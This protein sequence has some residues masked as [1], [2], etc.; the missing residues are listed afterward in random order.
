MAGRLPRLTADELIRIL[1]RHGFE[2]VSQR[3][4]HQ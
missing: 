1:R 4:S 2:L 3:G